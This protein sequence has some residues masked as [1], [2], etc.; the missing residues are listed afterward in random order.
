MA[1]FPRGA[2]WSTGLA[3]LGLLFSS[4]AHYAVDS[5][6]LTGLFTGLNQAAAL[7]FWAGVAPF[8]VAVAGLIVAM[9]TG[10]RRRWAL[11]GGVLVAGALGGVVGGQLA[12]Y[13]FPMP[14]SDYRRAPGWLAGEVQRLESAWRQDPSRAPWY[15][16]RQ[17]P[18]DLLWLRLSYARTA[19]KGDSGYPATVY[20]SAQFDDA[21][22][23]SGHFEARRGGA[24][25][26]RSARVRVT[27]VPERFIGQLETEWLDFDGDGAI[28]GLRVRVVPSAA[29]EL[30]DTRLSAWLE[31]TH[32]KRVGSSQT[33]NLRMGAWEQFFDAAELAETEGPWLLQAQFLGP[34]AGDFSF[35][36]RNAHRLALAD[37]AVLDGAHT[38]ILPT[39]D[40]HPIDEDGD[41]RFE[42]LAITFELDISFPGSYPLMADLASDG[43]RFA[44]AARRFRFDTVGRH[45]ATL[46]FEGAKLAAAPE[47]GP[48]SIRSVQSYFDGYQ[49]VQGGTAALFLDEFGKT[50]PWRREQFEPIARSGVTV[51]L[52]RPVENP[53]RRSQQ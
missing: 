5:Q 22:E 20:Y 7:L 41:G 46:R 36:L 13:Q 48:W 27:T 16:F 45:R 35:A 3:L 44:S 1:R 43:H 38:R 33:M 6:R 2:V 53:V 12:L 31:D 49:R 42:A 26:L 37:G 17:P 24:P 15:R 19:P 52:P 8:A 11:F 4:A 30:A 50:G 14:W 29:A 34:E 18:G 32:R 51:E 40:E 21:T 28:N 23:V 9:L 25:R 47:D 39:F 10:I